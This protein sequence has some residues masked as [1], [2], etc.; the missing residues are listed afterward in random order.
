LFFFC[1]FRDLPTPP[2]PR[3]GFFHPPLGKPRPMRGFQKWGTMVGG[4]FDKGLPFESPRGVKQL[5]LFQIF[6][7]VFFLFAFNNTPRLSQHNPF[8]LWGIK[9]KSRPPQ[10]NVS[11]RFFP[12]P[13]FVALGFFFFLISCLFIFCNFLKY[14]GFFV[15]RWVGGVGLV[16]PPPLFFFVGV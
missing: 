8:F 5:V 3:G 15:L 12:T 7:F 14:R 2:P 16:A 6:L 4:T 10:K 1:V 13:P 11:G 9:P